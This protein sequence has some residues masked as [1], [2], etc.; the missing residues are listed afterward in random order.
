MK[1]SKKADAPMDS[2]GLPQDP[3]K[4]PSKGQKEL[5]VVSVPHENDMLAQEM[6]ELFDED[7]VTHQ[8]GSAEPEKD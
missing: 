5:H 8:H 3:N 7:R 1:N 4:V 2:Q 6:A